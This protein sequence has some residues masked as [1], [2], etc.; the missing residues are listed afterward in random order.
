MQNRSLTSTTAF[1]ASARRSTPEPEPASIGQVQ[2]TAGQR[3][4]LMP[5]QWYFG[6]EAAQ[7]RTLLGSCLA[8]TLWHP[9]QRL[10]GMCH[11]L[12]PRRRAPRAAGGKAPLDGRYGDEAVESLLREL[13]RHGTRP[14]DYIAH[15]YGGADTM[16][17]QAGV[18]LNV[19][20]S[21]IEQGWNLIDHHGFQLE[22]VDVGDYVPRTVSLE[23]G[24]GAVDVR[25]GGR[26]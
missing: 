25:R 26:R 22:G 12:L 17:D 11:Y 21:N 16:P 20:E 2:A 3:L 4:F 23:L 13:Q 18:K 15:L 6:R 24:T 7:L 10:G 19:G 14:Q 9:Q 8:I 1:A 5:G